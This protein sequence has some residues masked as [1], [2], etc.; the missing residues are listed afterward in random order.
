MSN[1]LIFCIISCAEFSEKGILLFSNKQPVNLLY[2]VSSE[3]NETYTVSIEFIKLDDCNKNIVK[4]S[5]PSTV[6]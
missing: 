4:T 2:K 6:P 1:Y 5:D 3:N